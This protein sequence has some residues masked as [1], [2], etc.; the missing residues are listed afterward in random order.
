MVE[1]VRVPYE[2]DCS[3]HDIQTIYHDVPILAMELIFFTIASK[4]LYFGFVLKARL[5]VQKHFLIAE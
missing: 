3:R 2:A 1:T 5:K 4:G